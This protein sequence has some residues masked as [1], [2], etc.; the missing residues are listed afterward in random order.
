MEINGT[1]YSRDVIKVVER[2]VYNKTK[3]GKDW[4]FGVVITIGNATTR[5]YIYS[6][7]EA[8]A[9]QSRKELI[10]QLEK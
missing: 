9:E 8:Q 1:W 5:E 4:E 10:K 2:V 6:E 3:F 7:T